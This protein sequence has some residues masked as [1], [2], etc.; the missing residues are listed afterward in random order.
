LKRKFQN[1]NGYIQCKKQPFQSKHYLLSLSQLEHPHT[2]AV[3]SSV[4]DKTLQEWAIP[5]GKVLMVVSDNG[6]NMVKAIK[7]MQEHEAVAQMERRH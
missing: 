2:T 6:A 4:L 3:L 5:A 7:L 1:E